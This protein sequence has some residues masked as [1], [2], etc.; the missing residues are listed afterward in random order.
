[1]TILKKTK[2]GEYRKIQHQTSNAS[3]TIALSTQVE[4]LQTKHSAKVHS[5]NE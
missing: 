1:M 4:E 3:C 2:H 5:A